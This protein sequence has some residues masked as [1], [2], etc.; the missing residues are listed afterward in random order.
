MRPIALAFAALLVLGTLAR[1]EP[2][3]F[4]DRPYAEARA[5]AAEQDRLFFVKGTAVWCAPCKAMDKNTFTDE[6]VKE[7]LAANAISVSVDVDDHPDLARELKIRAMPT[8]V[9]FRGDE[10]LGRAVGYRG[11]D[12]LIAWLTAAKAGELDQF[13]AKR[14]APRAFPV[15]DAPEDPTDVEARLRR[16]EALARAGQHEEATSEFIWLWENMLKH[17]R[18]MLGVRT[19]FMAGDMADLAGDSDHA[20]K[21]FAKL[22]DE[23]EAKLRDANARSS[24]LTDWIVLSADILAEPGPVIAWVERVADRPE[25]RRAIDRNWHHLDSVFIAAERYELM[26]RVM[27][28]PAARIAREIAFDQMNARFDDEFDYPDGYDPVAAREEGFSTTASLI[29]A[30]LLAAGRDDEAWTVAE[31]ALAHLDKPLLRRAF[32][33]SALALATPSQRHIDLLEDDAE[34]ADLRARLAAAIQG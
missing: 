4:T 5:L 14:A 21:A 16:A 32:A 19:S 17:N 2:A 24:D 7:W 29:H 8:M 9:L 11:P 20:R 18:S 34:A 1:A 12:E 6:R 33:E 10:E 27:P 26:G 30:A 13:E 23:T 25:G 31:K 28:N 15:P 22:R 3:F